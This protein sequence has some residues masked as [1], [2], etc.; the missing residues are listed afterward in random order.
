MDDRQQSLRVHDYTVLATLGLSTFYSSIAARLEGD[1]GRPVSDVALR[2]VLGDEQHA[3]APGS[4]ARKRKG[5]FD[6]GAVAGGASS[7][8][9]S[10]RLQSPQSSGLFAETS[11]ALGK[12]AQK[13]ISGGTRGRASGAPGARLKS[14]FARVGPD[15]SICA[16]GDLGTEMGAAESRA[17]KGRAHTARADAAAAAAAAG[18]ADMRPKEYGEVWFDR[19]L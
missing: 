14:A 12:A 2:R 1:Q 10:S 9:A 11:S 13:K 4:P 6:N 5:A 17:C 15:S 16:E 19:Y 8:A 7:A 18:A 3:C